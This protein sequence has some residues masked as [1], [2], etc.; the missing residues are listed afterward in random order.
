M[1]PFRLFK[2]ITFCP[3]TSF[4]PSFHYHHHHCDSLMQSADYVA[5]FQFPARYNPCHN[6]SHVSIHSGIHCS[7]DRDLYAPYLNGP[8]TPWEEFTISRYPNRRFRLMYLVEGVIE[9]REG[10]DKIYVA[11]ILV[12][13]DVPGH[14]ISI[15]ANF[16]FL[17]FKAKVKVWRLD[18]KRF[19]KRN[20]MMK[21]SSFWMNSNNRRSSLLPS[22]AS[23]F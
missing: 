8:Y 13:G 14:V 9:V 17:T 16:G 1:L 12:Y 7:C 2:Y 21:I 3:V 23:Q 20:V 5:D 10:G 22:P 18:A 15:H 6:L 4:Q 11:E 19:W